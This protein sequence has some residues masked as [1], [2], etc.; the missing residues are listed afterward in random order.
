MGRP[1]HSPEHEVP[2]IATKPRRKPAKKATRPARPVSEVL[3][4]LAYHLHASKVI[5][6][7]AK[8]R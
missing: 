3:L 7:P 2:V 5:A 8:G 6:R 4:E 1:D